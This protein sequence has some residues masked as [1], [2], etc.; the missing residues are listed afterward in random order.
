M[1]TIIKIMKK[2]IRFVNAYVYHIMILAVLYF[3]AITFN[4]RALI[5]LAVIALFDIAFELAQ[6]KKL[7][8]IDKEAK[9]LK[10]KIDILKSYIGSGTNNVSESITSLIRDNESLSQEQIDCLLNV[11]DMANLINHKDNDESQS[12][13]EIERIDKLIQ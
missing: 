12:L 9:E 5:T 7:N 3:G 8:D 13:E 10:Y 4:I 6:N 11:R 1:T 2:I